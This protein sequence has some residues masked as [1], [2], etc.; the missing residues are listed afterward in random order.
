MDLCCGVQYA[1]VNCTR[2]PYVSLIK[3]KL[4]YNQ[5][6]FHSILTCSTSCV[7]SI[8][9]P[10]I[11]CA[12]SYARL[13]ESGRAESLC[14]RTVCSYAHRLKNFFFYNCNLYGYIPLLKPC[15][16]CSKLLFLPLATTLATHEVDQLVLNFK[17]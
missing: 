2:R 15:S 9:S 11:S 4:T 7:S 16:G 5:C 13:P 6:V 14:W 1:H 17:C 8:V 10:G 12:L 3:N